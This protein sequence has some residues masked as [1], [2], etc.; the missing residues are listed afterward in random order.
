MEGLQKPSIYAVPGIPY[1]VPEG[2]RT[3]VKA[4]ADAWEIPEDKV[5]GCTEVIPKKHKSPHS[6]GGE[7]KKE[8]GERQL[9]YVNAR[10]FYFYVM[11][12]LQK[13]RWKELTRLTGRKIAAMKYASSKAK[14]HMRLEPEYMDKA[15]IVLDLIKAD[16]IVFPYRKK[17]SIDATAIVGNGI[18]QTT[19]PLQQSDAGKQCFD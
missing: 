5:L 2:K 18:P 1:P 15:Q 13:Y 11:V 19:P 4:I 8:K 14:E 9:E 12:E 17:P 16:L 6:R 10:K 7:R 3:I